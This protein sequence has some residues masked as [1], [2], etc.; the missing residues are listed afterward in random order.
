MAGFLCGKAGD[1]FPPHP[2]QCHAPDVRPRSTVS[3]GLQPVPRG[4]VGEIC[5]VSIMRQS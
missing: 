4:S 5:N 1:E 2:S 3:F